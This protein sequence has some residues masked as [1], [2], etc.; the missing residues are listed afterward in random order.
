MIF[1]GAATL[2]AVGVLAW[3]FVANYGLGTLPSSAQTASAATMLRI[4]SG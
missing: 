3:L 2:S 4:A 1:M